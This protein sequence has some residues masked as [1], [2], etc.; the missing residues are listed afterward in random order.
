M[1]ESKTVVLN[2]RLAPATMTALEAR[3][4]EQRQP[5]RRMAAMIIEDAVAKQRLALAAPLAPARAPIGQQE[6]QPWFKG[7]K[8]QAAG[9]R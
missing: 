5:V 8:G 2:L 4:T 1:S 9:K 3:A 7:A 6:V